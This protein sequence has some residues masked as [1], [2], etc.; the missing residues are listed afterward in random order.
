MDPPVPIVK[1]YNEP[2]MG[3]NGNVHLGHGLEWV[4]GPHFMFI[5]DHTTYEAMNMRF[6]IINEPIGTWVF[7]DGIW[8]IAT[9]WCPPS[10]MF[11]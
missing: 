4:H 5:Y 3:Y 10:D 1:D 2:Y 8:S 11:V 9:R 7:L 6:M